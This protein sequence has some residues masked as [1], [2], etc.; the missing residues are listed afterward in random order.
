MS[1]HAL[2][3]RRY[4]A[5][6]VLE[7]ERVERIG[8]EG[9]ASTFQFQ[10]IVNEVAEQ[11]TGET[12]PSPTVEEYLAEWLLSIKRKNAAS[13]IERYG[14]S[15]RLFLEALHAGIEIDYITFDE[16]SADPDQNTQR[17][18][19]AIANARLAPANENQR[20]AAATPQAR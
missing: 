4:G 3:M 6:S 15:V 8:L 1:S 19:Q 5:P 18:I 17:L 14:N 12:L 9:Q 7:W 16:G 20:H 10:K 13:T 11:I 2:V